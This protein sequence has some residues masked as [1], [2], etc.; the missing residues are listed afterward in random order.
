MSDRECYYCKRTDHFEESCV[1][2]LKI[3]DE[4]YERSTLNFEEPSGYCNDCGVEHGGY[5]HD[6]CDVETCPKC[7]GQFFSCDCG[8]M[9]IREPVEEK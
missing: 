4:I 5:H 1:S 3:G 2:R 7:G 9:V 6:N 8:W